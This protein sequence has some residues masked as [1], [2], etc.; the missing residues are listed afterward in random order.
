MTFRLQMGQPLKAPLI[1]YPGTTLSAIALCYLLANIG[2]GFWL[3][4]LLLLWQMV[5]LLNIN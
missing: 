4:T 1:I 5:L 2:L 3:A